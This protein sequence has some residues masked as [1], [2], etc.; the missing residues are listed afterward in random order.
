MRTQ[1][2]HWSNEKILAVLGN[3][4]ARK[5]VQTGAESPVAE[6]VLARLSAK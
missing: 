4:C 3:A 1:P 5:L 6:K 2:W